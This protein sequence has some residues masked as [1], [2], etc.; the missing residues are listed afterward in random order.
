MRRWLVV[1]AA[2]DFVVVYVVSAVVV[3]DVT[4]GAVVIVV[5]AAVV[6]GFFLNPWFLL[7]YYNDIIF[8]Q[9]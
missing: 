7:Q 3:V 1:V 5:D 4:V 6:E 2:V 8:S 9:V